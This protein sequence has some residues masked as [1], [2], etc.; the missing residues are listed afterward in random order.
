ME[1]YY[2]DPVG[3]AAA[4]DVEGWLHTGDL[5]YR[6]AGRL[7]LCRWTVQGI[8]HQGGDEHCAQAD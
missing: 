8:D 5:A 2:K 3:T 6:D 7:L 4:L 1:G